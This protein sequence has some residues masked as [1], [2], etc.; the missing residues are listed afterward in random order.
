MPRVGIREQQKTYPVRVLCRVM[1]VSTSAYYSWT[2]QPEMS[3]KTVQTTRLEA[4]GH[5]FLMSLGSR[6]VRGAYL[7]N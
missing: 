3:E 1:E 6:M 4:K 7:P 2:K 5:D